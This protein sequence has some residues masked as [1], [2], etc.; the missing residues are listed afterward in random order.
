MPHSVINS[1][2]I[3]GELDSAL[4]IAGLLE[5]RAIVRRSRC[6]IGRFRVRCSLEVCHCSTNHLVATCCC[7][8]H[9]RSDSVVV[10]AWRT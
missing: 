4:G 5:S 2:L 6:S 10:G 8:V 1:F 7:E 9:A 3:L